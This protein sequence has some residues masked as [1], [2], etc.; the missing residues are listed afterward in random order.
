MFSVQYHW[1]AGLAFSSAGGSVWDGFAGAAVC[2]LAGM[3]SDPFCPHAASRAVSTTVPAIVR[4]DR[5]GNK[6][7]LDF[8][9]RITV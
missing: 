3:Y 9:I 8:T 6:S 5:R 4:S 2:A 1:V 7:K